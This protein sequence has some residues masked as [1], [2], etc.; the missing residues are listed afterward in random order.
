MEAKGA[1]YFSLQPAILKVSGTYDVIAAVK[2][3]ESF[4]GVRGF[5]SEG[6]TSNEGKVCEMFPCEPVN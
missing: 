3:A 4:P 5:G 2:V 6:L 1:R